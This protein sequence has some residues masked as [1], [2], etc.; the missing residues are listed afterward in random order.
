MSA[1]INNC[2]KCDNYTGKNVSIG[3]DFLFYLNGTATHAYIDTLQMRNLACVI[4][5]NLGLKPDSDFIKL[6]KLVIYW[7]WENNT[8]IADHGTYDYYLNNS[9]DKVTG[10]RLN[11]SEIQ[12]I[13][14]AL[15]DKF[16]PIPT[17]QD[18]YFTYQAKNGE[19]DPFEGIVIAIVTDCTG[20][21]VPK[22][23]MLPR[24]KRLN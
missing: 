1:Q 13:T 15:I 18:N 16:N 10:T 7:R 2:H 12:L 9:T 14:D 22:R 17:Q 4:G 3:T 23:N 5:K 24:L 8:H 6:D 21:L 11:D 19:V 20:E